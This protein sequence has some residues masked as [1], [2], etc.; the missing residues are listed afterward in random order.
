MIDAA[1]KDGDDVITFD[2]YESLMHQAMAAARKK[3][4]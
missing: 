4:E 1:D 3:H 2:E